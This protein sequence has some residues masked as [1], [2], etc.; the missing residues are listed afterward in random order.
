MW[1]KIIRVQSQA[2][3]ALE[4]IFI[5]KGQKYI[6]YLINSLVWS[7]WLSHPALPSSVSF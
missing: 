7:E 1:T 3:Y 6:L 2:L 5:P 4:N